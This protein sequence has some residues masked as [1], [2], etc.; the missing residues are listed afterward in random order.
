VSVAFYPARDYQPVVEFGA[1]RRGASKSIVLTD[2]QVYTLAECL[3]KIQNSMYKR[4][5]EPVIRCGSGNFRLNTPMSRRGL[6]RMFLGTEYMSDVTG[7]TL[8]CTNISCRAATIARLHTC[9]AGFVVVCDDGFNFS[10]VC[11]TMPNASK[12]IDYPL[13][14]KEHVTF[15]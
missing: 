4:E 3:H 15:V 2:E 1:M 13:L 9:F 14:Y 10:C 6:A 8:S 12:H 5:E 7:P 11:G